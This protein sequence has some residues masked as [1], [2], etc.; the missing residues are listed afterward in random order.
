MMGGFG[1]DSRREGVGKAVSSG[2]LLLPRWSKFL[3]K[4]NERLNCDA[5]VREGGFGNRP[6]YC[7]NFI[8]LDSFAVVLGPTRW[9]FKRGLYVGFGLEDTL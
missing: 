4:R 6:N 1:G 7:V 9:I 5:D 8:I 2:W 3:S